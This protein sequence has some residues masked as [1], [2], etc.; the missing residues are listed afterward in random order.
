[1]WPRSF[2]SSIQY[3]LCTKGGDFAPET[4]RMTSKNHKPLMSIFSARCKKA[5]EF[6]EL[7]LW[8]HPGQH[9][10][11]E[12][13][14]KGRRVTASPELA[15]EL[16]TCPPKLVRRLGD[17]QK[18]RAGELEIQTN[19]KTCPGRDESLVA[20]GISVYPQQTHLVYLPLSQRLY[21]PWIT[22]YR[23]LCTALS[24]SLHPQ[25]YQ[26]LHSPVHPGRR[27]VT[28][29]EWKTVGSVHLPCWHGVPCH[30]QE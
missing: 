14:G 23:L 16:S 28:K 10:D 21:R 7:P 11:P 29:L 4:F 17:Y 18:S 2:S 1:M 3:C 20:G 25:V 26:G 24:S 8:P 27:A 9:P 22:S 6:S 5:S 12:R 15:L 19:K 13:C 30:E